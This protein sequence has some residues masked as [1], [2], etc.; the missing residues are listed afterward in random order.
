MNKLPHAIGKGDAWSISQGSQ[1]SNVCDKSIGIPG[2]LRYLVDAWRST[3]H[4]TN[5]IYELLH[6]YLLT[7]TDVKH[8][9]RCCLICDNKETLNEIAHMNK[10]SCLMLHV[11]D[12]LNWLLIKMPA[13]IARDLDQRYLRVFA[14]AIDAKWPPYNDRQASG[15]QE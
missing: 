10:I 13:Q 15:M 9:S 2:D 12:N 3:G 4:L 6:R 14:R 1:L 5:N 7:R 8:L 11:T